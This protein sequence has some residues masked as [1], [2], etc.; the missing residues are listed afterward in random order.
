MRHSRTTALL[1][2]AAAF[3]LRLVVILQLKDHP[4]L[5]GDA[6]LDTT[7][8][9][10][11]ARSVI[12]GNLGLGPG[13]YFVSP[14]YIYFLALFYGLSGSLTTVRVVQGA[15][16]TVGVACVFVMAREWFSVRAAWI[17]AALAAFC[18][19][20]VFYE[21]LILQ[22][23][24][25]PALAAMALAA[26][27]L[28]L[29]RDH[30]RWIA[31]SGL[32]FGLQTLNRPNILPAA[33]VVVVM[34]VVICRPKLAGWMA[35]GIVAGLLPVSAR[36]LIVSGQWSLVSSHGGLAFYIG[37][38]ETAT[39]LFQLVPGIRP[40]IEGQ[41]EDSRKVAERA[42][43]HALNDAEV[44][45]YFRQK[46]LTWI[47]AHP[48][49]AAR[50]MAKKLLLA[51]HADHTPLPQSYEFF[52]DEAGTS[53]KW[54]P[55]NPWLIVP[56]G[57]AGLLLVAPMSHRREF[58]VWASFVPAYAA[59]VAV[60]YVAERY[61]LALF[62]PLA[63]GAGALVDRV[64]SVMQPATATRGTKRP[65][66]ASLRTGLGVAAAV[67]AALFVCVNWPMNVTDGVAA[68]RAR[69]V[70]KSAERGQFAE[71]DAWAARAERATPVPNT[72]ETLGKVCLQAGRLA[73]TKGA[74]VEAERL[75]RRVTVLQP[76]VED[77]WAQ[78][79]FVLLLGNRLDDSATAL[80]RAVALNPR[81]VVAL[82]GLA[83][84]ELKLNRLPAARA[85]AESALA[86]D[87]QEQLALAVSAALR[88]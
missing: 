44:S 72:A 5:Q 27:T 19:V 59:A 35:A 43:G 64:M 50:L 12:G 79:G 47:S 60:F 63:V 21:S 54:T 53:L 86:I 83:M 31:V 77:A 4:L 46:S 2:L 25:D 62:M 18:G 82:G 29:C 80:T 78:L 17:A 20:L 49:D 41:S 15:L 65:A 28:G 33:I 88:R 32:V 42:V 22:S 70:L 10:D 9:F 6:G 34:L 16:G 45:D 69:M 57:L 24:I 74:N 3:A 68:E 58:L 8:Y 48:W 81:D 40:E 71:A 84:S 51:F 13:L 55:V 37:N 14:F 39:G 87:P 23:S 52:A 38:N 26:L 76:D 56:L 66:P 67:V 30:K 73:M 36:N 7:A 1:G 75:F 11:L 61:R 85:H